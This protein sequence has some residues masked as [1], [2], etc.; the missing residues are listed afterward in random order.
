M[1]L[2]C[3]IRSVLSILAVVGLAVAPVARPAMGMPA[4]IQADIASDHVA[5]AMP[6]EA[7]PEDMPCC[8][9]KAPIPDCGKDCL[10]IC[11][12]QLLSNAVQG[13]G[14]VMPHGPA[15]VLPFGND[16]ALVGLGQSPP[17]RPPKI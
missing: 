5:M 12:T 13:A 1:K 4:I 14:L 3:A 15:N 9:K 10:A 17:L 11:A 7:M 16:T 8:P 6:E 2:L